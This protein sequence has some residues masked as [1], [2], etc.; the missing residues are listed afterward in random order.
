MLE[1]VS[2]GLCAEGVNVGGGRTWS[3]QIKLYGSVVGCQ[4]SPDREASVM[5]V[6]LQHM[7]RSYCLTT[8]HHVMVTCSDIFWPL[9]EREIIQR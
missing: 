2:C 7:V 9:E 1:V 3:K 6:C 5:H 4:H 8:S